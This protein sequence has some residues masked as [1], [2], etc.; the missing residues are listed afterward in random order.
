MSDLNKAIA[1]T[2]ADKPR[3]LFYRMLLSY[4]WSIRD[5]D[6]MWEYAQGD[7]ETG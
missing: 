5:V 3:A 6:E 4:G 2:F 1:K 7:G